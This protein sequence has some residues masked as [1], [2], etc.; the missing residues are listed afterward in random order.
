MFSE[1]EYQR[2]TEW[3]VSA[4]LGMFLHWGLYAIPGRGEWV[5]SDEQMDEQKYRKY[6]DEFCPKNYDPSSWAKAAKKAG[7][8]YVVLTAK[9][10]DGF[11]LFDSKYT[12]FKS[13][14]TRFGRDI[15]REFVDAMRAEGLKVGIYYSLLDWHHEDYPH[16]GD[17]YHPMRVNLDESNEHRDFDR[18][19]LYLYHQVEELCTNY[20]KL[21]IL[22]FDFSYGEMR[23]EKWGASKLVRMIRSLQPDVVM[24]NRLEVS[25]EGLGSLAA[26]R[27]TTYH[28]D[29]VTPEQIIPP[30]GIRDNFGKP[31]IW[32]AC[33]TMNGHWG[34]CANDRFFKPPVMLIRK[35]VECVSKGGNMLLNIGPDAYGN[36][37]GQS[38]NI[39]DGFGKWMQKNHESIYGCGS[40]GMKKP[41]YG[42]ITRK[43][44]ILYYH[45]FENT[46]GPIPLYGLKKEQI[47]N[48]RWLETGA[49]IP[50]SSSWVHSNY[51]EIAFANLGPDPVLPD[52]I[53]TVIKVE[54]S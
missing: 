52:S 19:Q 11:C 23:G 37:P 34:Y 20:G 10:H 2:R 4:R 22:W 8:R 25:G 17:R 39:L 6:F 16:Y 49:E 38:L 54:I 21:D 42:R 32:E 45:L 53:D 35:L 15:V 30:C 13:T 29:F 51:P 26:G 41:E 48:I 43:G 14:N 50:I 18:Y 46:I 9:H 33:V 27:P 3:Y 7:M 5:R 24:N 40:S 1:R 44:N 36:F 12:D 47:K 28:G 31:M